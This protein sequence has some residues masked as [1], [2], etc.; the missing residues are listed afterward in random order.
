V[1]AEA[2][3]A[4]RKIQDESARADTLAVLAPRLAELGYPQEALDTAEEIR[5]AYDRAKCL[6]PPWRSACRRNCCPKPWPP[7]GKSEAPMNSA[8]VLIALAARLP[9]EPSG[10]EALAAARKSEDEYHRAEALTAL[11]ARLPPDL[12]ELARS[13]GRRKGNQGCRCRAG[14]DRPGGA[15]TAGTAGPKPW[16]PQGKS[17]MRMPAPAP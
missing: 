13:P 3:A 6:W 9:P 4:A 15:P 11:A 10:P 1:L 5:Y 2:L 7:P 17:R 12:Q 16:P 14:P 8:R